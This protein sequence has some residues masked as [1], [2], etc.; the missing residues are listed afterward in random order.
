MFAFNIIH[1]INNNKKELNDQY[2]QKA[3][4]SHPFMALIA[5][6]QCCVKVMKMWRYFPFKTNKSYVPHLDFDLNISKA[7]IIISH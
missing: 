3:I 2:F 5:E 7:E 1:D 4:T 6:L